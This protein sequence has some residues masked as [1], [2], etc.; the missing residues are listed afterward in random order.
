MSP[1][2]NGKTFAPARVGGHNSRSFNQPTG[3]QTEPMRIRTFFALRLVDTVVKQLADHADSLCEYDR[4]L[5]VD[6]VDSDYYHLTLC[7]LGDTGLDQ[8]EQLEI[9]AAER[10]QALRSFQVCLQQLAYYPINRELS[11]IAAL[12][13]KNA[14]LT[15]LQAKVAALVDQVG[16]RE[17]TADFK[18]H[19]TLGKLP[20][21]NRF[22]QPDAWPG[23]ELYSLVDAVVLFQ[24]KQG[25]H[26]SVYTPLFEV[27]LQ[28]LD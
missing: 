1:G 4:S 18:P 9:L 28:D 25:E 10:L 16:L 17:G 6:W 5:E 13:A 24:S 2:I 19:I 22:I 20:R 7:F 3:K 23:F 27:G 15:K 21:N 8:I 14:C 26:G 12:P 11:L